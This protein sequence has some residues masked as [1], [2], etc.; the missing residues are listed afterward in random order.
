MK[1]VTSRFGEIDFKESEVILLPKG[2]LGFS[3]LT[4]TGCRV[5]ILAFLRRLTVRNTE[6]NRKSTGI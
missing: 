4:T 6:K 1:F 3:Q 2:I 5:S